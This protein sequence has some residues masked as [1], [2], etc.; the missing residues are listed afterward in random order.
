M[1][2][3]QNNQNHERFNFLNGSIN[4]LIVD[5]DELALDYIKDLLSPIKLYS[6][7]IGHNGANALKCLRSGIRFHVCILD[8][9]IYD[10]EHDEYYILKQ[11]ANHCSVLVLTGSKS[12]E[13]GAQ[14]ILYGAKAV[15]EKGINLDP[16]KL[17]QTI[18]RYA[19]LNLVHSR[20]DERGGDTLSLSVKILFEKNPSSVTEWADYLRITDRQLRNLWHQ[21]AGFGAKHVLFLHNLFSAAFN[22]YMCEIFPN[23]CTNKTDQLEYDKLF[24]Y[25]QRYKEIINFL[26]T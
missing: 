18:N 15:F 7:H 6:L 1:S 9:G 24:L 19:L 22:H 23:N 16:L 5:D 11:Y 17:T 21:G 13:K 3:I 4:I 26:L 10:V 20:Y 8:L 14:S 12:P 25:Y 2:D